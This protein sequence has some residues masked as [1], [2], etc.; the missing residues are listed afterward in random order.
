MWNAGHLGAAAGEIK[1]LAPPPVPGATED[2]PQERNGQF[3]FQK[4]NWP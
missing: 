2:N 4:L 1:R 3:E